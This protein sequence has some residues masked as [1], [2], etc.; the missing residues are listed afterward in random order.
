MLNT[1]CVCVCT[2][3][4]LL[5]IFPMNYDDGNSNTS[6]GSSVEARDKSH[7]QERVEEEEE[8]DDEEGRS[9]WYGLFHIPCSNSS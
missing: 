8:E 6:Q 1:K 2:I 4:L 3:I 7:Y 9:A 5:C